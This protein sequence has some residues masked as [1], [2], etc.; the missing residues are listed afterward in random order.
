M[1]SPRAS[2]DLTDAEI[3]AVNAV[4]HSPALRIGPQ[5]TAFE[6]A[7]AAYTGTAHGVG[8]N[9]GTSGLHLCMIAAG[10]ADG[11][12]VITSPFSFIASANSIL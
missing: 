2:P 5:I 6:R 9:S 7:L 10:V 8:V 3:A 12:P 11:D 1:N 4:M